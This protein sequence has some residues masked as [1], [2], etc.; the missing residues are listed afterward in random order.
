VLNLNTYLIKEHVGMLKLTDTYDIFDPASGEQVGVAKEEPST[1]VKILRLFM[2]KQTLP[3]AVVVREKDGE[4]VFSIHRG[5]TLIRSKVYI[6]DRDSRVVGYFHS[7]L[8]SIG[9]GFW[10]YDAE[11]NHFAEVKG[12]WKGWNFRFL[13]SDGHE[14]GTVSKKW[15][16]I[17]KE[18]FTSADNYIIALSDGIAEKEGGNM[19]LLAAGLAIDII[20]KER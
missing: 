6:R 2:N 13:T 9:G 11:G 17:A 20:Y 4:P 7:K 8:L 16:G 18:L 3:T 14:L 15:A 19:L 10:V 1:L 5:F 12:D